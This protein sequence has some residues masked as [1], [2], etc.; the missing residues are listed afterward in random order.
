MCA[1]K[2][3][4]SIRPAVFSVIACPATRDKSVIS[5]LTSA[6]RY[7]ARMERH[8]STKLTTTSVAVQRASMERT[9]IIISTNACQIRAPLARLA[10]MAS[11]IIHALAFPE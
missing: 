4:V 1:A 9:A 2:E 11:L 7:R 10:S 6:W 3:S 8:A 5:M